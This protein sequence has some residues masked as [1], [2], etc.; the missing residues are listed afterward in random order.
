MFYQTYLQTLAWLVIENGVNFISSCDEIL[1]LAKVVMFCR[2]Y[3]RTLAWLVI[4]KGVNFTSSCDDGF[5][6]W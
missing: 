3:L 1:S 4:E 2:A 5:Q 6:F